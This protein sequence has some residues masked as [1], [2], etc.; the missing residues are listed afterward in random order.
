MYKTIIADTKI[1]Q[2]YTY[3][4]I[5]RQEKDKKTK[6]NCINLEIDMFSNS[7]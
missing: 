1:H 5:K 4:K 7:F 6:R 3:I 2:K